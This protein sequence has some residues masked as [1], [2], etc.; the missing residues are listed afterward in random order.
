MPVSSIYA[1]SDLPISLGGHPRIGVRSVLQSEGLDQVGE[2]AER[3]AEH[4]L[5]DVVISKK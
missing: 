3:R 5:G 4:S 1:S 2:H